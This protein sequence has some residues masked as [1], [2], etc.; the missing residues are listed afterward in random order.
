MNVR[1]AFRGSPWLDLVLVLATLGSTTWVATRGE[2]DIEKALGLCSTKWLW[3]M[4]DN[5]IKFQAR[6][7]RFQRG[8]PPRPLR[9]RYGEIHPWSPI[10]WV[11]R[12]PA[13]EPVWKWCEEFQEKKVAPLL[14]IASIGLGAI[15]VRRPGARRVRLGLDGSPRRLRLCWPR[16]PSSRNCCCAG[17]IL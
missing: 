6:M 17:S 12:V 9:E 14:I 15:A 4:H 2:L 13:M 10:A 1:A 11:N 7:A 16:L 8:D 5:N 3:A